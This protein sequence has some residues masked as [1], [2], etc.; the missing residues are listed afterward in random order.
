MGNGE[1]PSSRLSRVRIPGRPHRLAIPTADTGGP[2]EPPR[3]VERNCE[4]SPMAIRPPLSSHPIRCGRP[5][6]APGAAAGHPRIRDSLISAGRAHLRQGVPTSPARRSA[7]RSTSSPAGTARSRTLPSP[8]WSSRSAAGSPSSA[9]TRWRRQPGSASGCA[10]PG[11]TCATTPAGEGEVMLGRGRH[12]P[13][14]HRHRRRPGHPGRRPLPGVG[15]RTG[16]LGRP[17][18]RRTPAPR[19][20]QPAS[21]R[22]RRRAPRPC[23]AASA[24]SAGGTGPRPSG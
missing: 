2:A 22:R 21:G 5:P 17:A 14:A 12:R 1:P 23:C 24:R 10:R 18:A 11:S 3:P 13:S 8:G 6:P 20:A 9:W 16:R 4:V 19:C 15:R 7:R